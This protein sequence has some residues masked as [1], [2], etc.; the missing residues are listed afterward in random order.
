M[1]N[2]ESKT[3]LLLKPRGF[4]AGVVR[5]IDIVR[6]ALE[7]FGP[8]IYVRKEIVHNRFVVE[9]L[10]AKG[11]IFVDSVDEVPEGERVIYSAHGVSP[12]V[13][14]GSKLR[15]LRVIDATCPLVTKVHVEA[16]KFA[17]EGYSLILIGHHDHDEVIGTLGEAPAVTQVVGSPEDVA[18]LTVPDPDRIAYL[19]Q[20][21][22]SLDETKD[23]IAA[24]QE[25]FP[26]IKGPAAQDICYATE[27]RQVA[28][29]QVASE[30]DLVLVVGS[31][32]SSNSNRL[33]EVARNLGTNAHLIDS[34]KNIKADWLASVRTIALTAGA[35]APECL[36]EEVVKFLMSQGFGNVKELEVMPENVRFGLPPEIVEAIA[37][38][39]ASAAA[40]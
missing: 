25:K 35:S 30:A 24:L 39:P 17:K 1:S 29:K 8:P 23:I 22:L 5:A 13:R 28:V 34:Y 11:A 26:N 10:Q 18:A 4:C 16:V 40:E 32:N 38:A 2:S 31:D 12:E 37:A 20:T 27:N 9:E 6:I 19:T 21:T 36:V 14:D 33:V 7:A 15:K 3:L